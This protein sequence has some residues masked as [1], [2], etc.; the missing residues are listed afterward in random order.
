MH[1]AGELAALATAIFWTVTALAFEKA[2]IRIGS[3][4]VNI[5]RLFMGF[6]FLSLFTLVYRGMLFPTDASAENW[7]WL[8]L[9]GLIGFVFGDLCLFKSYTIIGSRF[10]M[11]MM[12][13]APPMA[14]IA[15]YFLL[16]ERLSLLNF[17]GM[18]LTLGGIS[19]AI[20]SRDNKKGRLTLKLSAKGLLLAFGGAVGQAFGLVLSKFGMKDYDPFAATQIRILTGMVGFS[21]LVA[22]MGRWKSVIK[23]VSNGSAMINTSIGS[24]FGPFLGVSFSLLAL[25]YTDTGI[26]AT[27]MAT[28]P[29]LIILPAVLLYKQKVTLM[30][31]I[32]SVV[33][34][35]GVTLF[36][37][38]F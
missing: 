17:I 19:L 9:S 12:T 37:V 6:V 11:L 7:T 36:F 27:L 35:G 16:D 38:K 4:A 13:L 10:A 15:G 26:A 25:K 14:A 5:I 34:I 21:I 8:V 22:I 33:S 20:F 31:I 18:L 3:L 29:I 1:Y 28:V 30:E 2:S 23:S 32:G 24:F